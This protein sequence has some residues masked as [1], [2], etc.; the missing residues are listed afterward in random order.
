MFSFPRDCFP[1]ASGI[2]LV[3]FELIPQEVAVWVRGTIGM[4]PAGTV[5]Q[6]EADRLMN[7]ISERVQKGEVRKIRALLQ[8]T[9]TSQFLFSS[10]R[11]GGLG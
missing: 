1:D 4:L 2:L 10:F 9:Y 7:G 6:G 11:I 8:G 3:L 5:K